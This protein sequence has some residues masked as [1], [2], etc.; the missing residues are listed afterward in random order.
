[1]R[2][3]SAFPMPGVVSG[4]AIVLAWFVMPELGRHWLMV[5]GMVLAVFG[6]TGLI[7]TRP[8]RHGY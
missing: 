3:V 1:M 6:G 7:V 8:H 4:F 2:L 5:G